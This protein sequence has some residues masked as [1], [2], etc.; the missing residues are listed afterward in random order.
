V[1]NPGSCFVVLKNTP[2]FVGGTHYPDGTSIGTNAKGINIIE[3][4]KNAEI[5]VSGISQNANIKKE[6]ASKALAV[7]HNHT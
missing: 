7:I 3:L 4:L 1:Q 6:D 2:T 5:A